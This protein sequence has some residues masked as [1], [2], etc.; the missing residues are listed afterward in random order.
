MNCNEW[1]EIF[2]SPALIPSPGSDDVFF[3]IFNS[4]HNYVENYISFNHLAR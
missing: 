3:T 4:Y 2:S 1:M